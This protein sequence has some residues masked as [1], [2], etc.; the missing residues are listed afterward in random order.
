MTDTG[1]PTPSD[2]PYEIDVVSI[3]SQV[4]YGSVGNSV[5][6]PTL[7]SFGLRVAAVPTAVLSNTPH[8]ATVSGGAMPPPWFE[9]YLRDLDLRGALKTASAIVS[10]YLA[11]A[12][13]ANILGTWLRS[14]LQQRSH[15]LVV[16]D[17]V[18]GDYDHGE[19]VAPSLA[20]AYRHELF[21]LAD[22]LTPNAFELERLAGS[23]EP[24]MEGIVKAA[25]TLMVDRTRWVVVTSALPETCAPDELCV[26]AVTKDTFHELR[27]PKVP[28]VAKGTGDLFTASL[29][30][31]LV[32]GGTLDQAAALA[33]KFVLGIAG[34]TL[35]QGSEELVLDGLR[36]KIERAS[37]FIH[38]SGAG[39]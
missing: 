32:G 15:L 12:A 14:Q 11:T 22:G 39:H 7:R 17:P 38:L 37:N 28:L 2:S 21:G 30:A 6:V 27:H 35:E 24:T 16:I 8:Y 13:H 25:R 3:Q 31:A 5:A 19:Y 26:I 34:T 10:G 4:V 36:G 9:G 1:P 29:V 18:I 23:Y 33:S 20:R